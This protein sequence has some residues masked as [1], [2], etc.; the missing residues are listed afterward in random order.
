M[1]ATYIKLDKGCFNVAFVQSFS[2]R[3][4]FIK[5]YYFK[6]K[7]LRTD[8][9]KKQY[10]AM[11]YKMAVPAKPKRYELPEVDQMVDEPDGKTRKKQTHKTEES[12]E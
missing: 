8:K 11:I 1:A 5:A 2:S 7:W 10:L 9:E 12:K 4:D 6:V 3:E